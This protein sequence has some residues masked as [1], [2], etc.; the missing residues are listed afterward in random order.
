V[1]IDTL[2]TLLEEESKDIYDAEKRLVKAIPKL[3]KAASSPELCQAFEEPLEVTKGQVERL[4]QVFELLGASAK[5]KP[6]AAMKGLVEEGDEVVSQDADDALKDAALIGAAQRVE[7]YEI[8]AYGTVRA[9][10]E[11]LG[12]SEAADLLEQTLNE[13]KEADEKLTTIA[14]QLMEGMG[15]E[16]TATGGSNGGSGGGMTAKRSQKTSRTRTSKA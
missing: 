6:C 5:S 3:A 10:A 12:N 8:A 11:R 13:E 15:D 14:D 4:E 1:R 9:M 7:H 2:S 16:M